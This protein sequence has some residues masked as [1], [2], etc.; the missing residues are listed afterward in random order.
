MDSCVI[1]ITG[2]PGSGKSTIAE[3]LKNK[4]ED[5]IILRVDEIR[6]FLTP[7]PTYSEEEREIVYRAL[8]FTALKIYQMNHT[9]IVDAT[10]NL[11]R[12]RDL[13]RNS[14]ERFVEVYVKCPLDVCMLREKTRDEHFGAPTNIYEKAKSGWPV[15]GVNVPYEE[16][17]NPE[18]TI[19]SDKTMPQEALDLIIKRLC[20]H[21]NRH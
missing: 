4:I 15:P 19:E 21:K 10:A 6:R 17:L 2:L 8:V 1:W 14:I 12:W 20:S 5:S 3:L 11:R 16:P 7:T 13:A 9:V 18:I